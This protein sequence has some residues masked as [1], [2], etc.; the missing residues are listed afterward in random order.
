MGL[1]QGDA[2]S[3]VLFKLVLEKVVRESNITACRAL[4]KIQLE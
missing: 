1:R 3:P 2:F 4:F